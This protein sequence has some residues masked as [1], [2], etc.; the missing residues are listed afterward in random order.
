LHSS[1]NKIRLSK[2]FADGK[3][4]SHELEKKSDDMDDP[5]HQDAVLTAAEVLERGREF[6]ISSRPKVAAARALTV[7]A[8]MDVASA[9][10]WPA[11]HP[12]QPAE[13]DKADAAR[14]VRASSVS[15]Q[16]RRTR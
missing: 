4:T 15:A 7:E 3:L 6:S 10:L 9:I 8:V 2:E 5:R 11:S 14:A 1:G 13:M 16:S 12:E